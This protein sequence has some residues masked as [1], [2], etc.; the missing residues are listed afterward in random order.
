MTTVAA[1]LAG[2]NIGLKA[3]GYGELHW[4]EEAQLDTA[5]TRVGTAGYISP[6]PSTA[7]SPR[8]HGGAV[9]KGQST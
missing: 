3:G 8:R 2:V 7:S 4:H 9:V 5:A 6:E 1:T